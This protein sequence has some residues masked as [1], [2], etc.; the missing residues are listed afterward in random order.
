MASNNRASRLAIRKETTEGTLL[1]ISSG[2][3]YIPLQSGFSFV[4]GLESLENQEIRSS[5]GRAA[6][7]SGIEQPQASFNEYLKHSGTEGTAPNWGALLEALFGSVSTNSTQ[8][9]TTSSSTTILIK[10]ASNGSEFPRGTPMLIKDG[11]NGYSIRFSDGYATNDVTPNFALSNAPASGIGV[12][13][14]VLYTPA[15]SDHPALSLWMLRGNGGAKEAITGARVTQMQMSV[16]VGEMINC[17]FQLEGLGYYFNP[18]RVDSTNNKL[19]FTDDTG[20]AT[21]TIPSKVYKDPHELARAVAAAMD[22]AN[23][24]VTH[25]CS[26]SNSTGKFTITATGTTLSLLW[27]TGTNGSDNTDTHIGTLMGYSD[28]A[29][30]TGTAAGTGYASDNA[31]TLTDSQTPSYD[32]SDPIIVKNMEFLVGG[33]QSS[34]SSDCVTSL[35]VNITNTRQPLKCIN[36]ESGVGGSIISERQVELVVIATMSTY[37]ADKFDKF[38]NNSDV[39][40][41]LSFG[42]KSGGNWVAGKCGGVYVPTAKISAFQLGDDNGIVTMQYTIRPYVNSSGQPEIY[43]GFV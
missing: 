15:D 40:C 6:P 23:A 5:I 42:V 29:D 27:K 13:K 8:R 38:L 31:Q 41:Q 37:D 25:S 43:L 28:A 10:M 22:T 1:D 34:F 19:N 3:Q 39:K 16:V 30:K 2:S 18:L 11:T 12:G 35:Q 21:A 9:L 14:A 32:S 26:Y 20:T 7:M 36:A 33:S 4:P 17:S 24:A